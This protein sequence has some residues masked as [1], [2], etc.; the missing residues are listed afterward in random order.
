MT[1]V[2]FTNGDITDGYMTYRDM[3]RDFNQGSDHCTKTR[4]GALAPLLATLTM[5]ELSLG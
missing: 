4:S 1:V 2:V 3:K 5:S